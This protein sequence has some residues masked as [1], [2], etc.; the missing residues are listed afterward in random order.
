MQANPNKFQ[1][2]AVGNKT[3]KNDPVFNIDNA[4]ISCDDVVKLLGVDI[5]FQLNFKCHIKSICRKAS[6]QLN[7]LK[8]IGSYLSRLNKLTTFH[9]FI[10]SN[11]NFCPSPWHFSLKRTQ[12]SSKKCKSERSDLYIM[13][14][15]ALTTNF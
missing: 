11:F 14:T 1:A 10:L 2:L 15:T 6:Q 8:R 13:I 4:T 7:V 12:K 3:H 9:T 5:D